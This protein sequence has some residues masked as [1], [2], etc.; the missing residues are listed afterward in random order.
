M[1]AEGLGIVDGKHLLLA[2]DMPRFA[3]ALAALAADP[4]RARA[5]ADAAHEL[6]LQCY[7][8][9]A[10]QRAVDDW[11]EQSRAHAAASATKASG[12]RAR[13]P[14]VVVGHDGAD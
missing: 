5:M 8:P 2:D 1:G 14:G 9:R 6:Q 11:L 4:A 10:L 13:A 12:W 3:D 7:A